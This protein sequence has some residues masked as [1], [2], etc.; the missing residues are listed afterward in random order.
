MVMVLSSDD[1]SEKAQEDRFD[2]GCVGERWGTMSRKWRSSNDELANDVKGVVG[3]KCGE[4]CSYGYVRH[5][6]VSVLR[7]LVTS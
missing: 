6:A 2:S 1:M 3:D 7:Q 5:F 4:Y